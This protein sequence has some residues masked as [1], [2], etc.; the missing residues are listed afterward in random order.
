MT[1]P[2]LILGNGESRSWFTPRKLENTITWGCNAVYRDGIVDN[3]VS[4]D[5]SMQQEIYESGYA[6]KNTCWFEEWNELPTSVGEHFYLTYT[7]KIH[8][9]GALSEKCVI[10]GNI[11][12]DIDKEMAK[13]SDHLDKKDLKQKLK[14]EIGLWVTWLADEDK[15]NNIDF[16]KDWAAGPTATH[17]AC[18]QGAKDIYL[19]GFDLSSYTEPLNNIYKGTDNYLPASSKGINSANWMTQLK[20]VFKEFPNTLFYWVDWSYGTP[21]CYNIKNVGYLTKTEFCGILNIQ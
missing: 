4:V 11:D 15:V 16:P 17:L 3:L 14:K 21:P 1:N 8:I 10:R 6:L 5:A 18:Q 13:Y 7:N 12:V 19:L 20:T 2:H 9:A